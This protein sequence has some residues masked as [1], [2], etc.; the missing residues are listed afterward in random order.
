MRVTIIQA[1]QMVTLSNYLTTVAIPPLGL[2]YVAASLEK[3]AHRVQFIDG[4]GEDITRFSPF[5]DY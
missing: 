4:V 3:A 5:Q 1:P 2:A